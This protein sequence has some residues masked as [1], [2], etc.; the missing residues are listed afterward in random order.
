MSKSTKSS[1]VNQKVI[2]T[3]AILSVVVLFLF[4]RNYF[5]L[6]ALAAILAFLFNPIYH[7]FQKKFKRGAVTMTVITLFAT[8]A[9]PL[10]VLLIITVEEAAKLADQVT[11]VIS[12][13]GSAGEAINTLVSGVNEQAEKLPFVEGDVLNIDKITQWLES[14]LSTIAS[15]TVNFIKS[16]A[17]GIAN[18]FTTLIIFL[19]VF[20]SLLKN[21]KK[22]VSWLEEL[23]PLGT[24]MNS[25]YLNKMGAMTSAMVKGQ[26]VIAVLQGLSGTISLWIIGV[27]YLAFWFVLLTFLSIIPLGGGIILIPFGI[28]LVLTG[29]V[30]QG[31][32]VLAWHFI[33]TTNIDNVLRPKFVPKSARLDPALT[34][35]SV[36]AGMGLFG[37]MGIVIGPVL[38]IVLLTTIETYLSYN[39][40]LKTVKK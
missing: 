6:I 13:S 9:I 8:I 38:M 23:N 29:N 21:Q 12:T 37:F 18:F 25:V 33:I 4:L 22:I 32:L 24:E 3:A 30:W 16:F 1:V 35:L 7:W 28:I 17:G 14:S 19:F 20:S 34:I 10:T 36:F 5:M 11:Q 26:F 27:D 39:K 2:V 15:G 31:L 40:E